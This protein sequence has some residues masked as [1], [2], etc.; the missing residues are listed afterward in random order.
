MV[1]T[2]ALASQLL[3][4]QHGSWSACPDV[5][6]AVVVDLSS[7]RQAEEGTRKRY[8]QASHLPQASTFA[9]AELEMKLLVSARVYK[10]ASEQLSR[11]VERR[12]HKEREEA[13]AAAAQSDRDREAKELASKHGRSALAMELQMLSLSDVEA[14]RL[15]QQ[16]ATNAPQISPSSEWSEQWNS[17]QAAVVAKELPTWSRMVHMGF[18][19]TGPSLVS[20]NPSSPEQRHPL[21]LAANPAAFAL[22]LLDAT[23]LDPTS[24]S[25]AVAASSS[26]A[27]AAAAAASGSVLHASAASGGRHGDGDSGGGVILSAAQKGWPSSGCTDSEQ[28]SGHGGGEGRIDGGERH[29][30]EGGEGEL[31]GGRSG[32]RR[33]ASPVLIVTSGHR[34]N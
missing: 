20:S 16:L 24:A 18:A 26:I 6:T 11:R 17:Q 34:L 32:R 21:A 13:R 22:N 15:K 27:A 10:S 33:R 3:L 28:A 8:R 19:A 14:L 12:K 9:I 31:G 1:F 4:Q 7:H 29:G 30:G 5:I 2:D 23:H 25:M